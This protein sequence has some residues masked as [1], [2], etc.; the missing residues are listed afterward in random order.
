VLELISKC[1]PVIARCLMK[2][3]GIIVLWREIES[4]VMINFA[5]VPRLD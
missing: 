1:E 2:K 4:S 3:V 5:E